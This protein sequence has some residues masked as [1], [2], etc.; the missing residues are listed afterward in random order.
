MGQ[1]FTTSPNILSAARFGLEFSHKSKKGEY[2]PQMEL[3]EQ[4]NGI[5][6]I[7]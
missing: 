7:L 5:F 2:L 3:S 6:G 1:N 4:V